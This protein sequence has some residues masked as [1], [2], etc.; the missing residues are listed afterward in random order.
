MISVCPHCHF[1]HE[2]PEELLGK[3]IRCEVCM[4]N[5][6]AQK[7][8][9]CRECG[10]ANSR[11]SKRC[12]NCDAV[13]KKKKFQSI[14]LPQ[15]SAAPLLEKVNSIFEVKATPVNAVSTVA[16][17]EVAELKS[18]HVPETNQVKLYTPKQIAWASFL[19]SVLGGGI[20]L[21]LNL[22]AL[23]RKDD[24]AKVAILTLASFF[25]VALFVLPTLHYSSFLA[26][27][28]QGFIMHFYSIQVCGAAVEAHQQNEGKIGSNWEATGAGLCGMVLAVLTTVFIGLCGIIY[29]F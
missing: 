29:N 4:N 14:N 7:S 19:G 22:R 28:A 24:I 8:I 15:L 20:L 27:V 6:I 10:S 11:L 25:G 9:Y 26:A 18:A 1:S 16:E 2:I 12:L 21:I 17:V 5:F 13:V 23:G 3:E